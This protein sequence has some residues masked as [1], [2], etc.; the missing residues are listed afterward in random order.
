MLKGI[1]IDSV[2]V[3]DMQALISRVPS[4]TLERMFTKVEIRNSFAQNSRAEYLA[5]RFAVKEAA[6]KAI[7]HH[8]KN[9]TFDFRIVETLNYEDG[10]PYIC[11]GE[12]LGKVMK[13][14]G[15]TDLR[16]SI[17]TEADTAT[18]IVMAQA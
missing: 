5:T 2:S 11:P 14:A 15:V 17:T 9:Q 3:S 1:G 4:G 10:C 8:T 16:V 18:A 13:E 6:F 12:E 7:A